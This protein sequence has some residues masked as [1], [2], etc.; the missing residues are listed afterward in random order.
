VKEHGIQRFVEQQRT[1]IRLLE[2]MIADF[3]DGRSK[4][5]YCKSAALLNPADLKS[6]LDA[7]VRKTKAD[8]VKPNDTKTKARILRGLL[9]ALASKKP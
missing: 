8:H 9:D 1:R 7:A 5:Y 2:K 4:S 6:S 3:D